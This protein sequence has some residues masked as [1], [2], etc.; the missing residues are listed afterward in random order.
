MSPSSSFSPSKS[1]STRLVREC[2]RAA[3]W[4]H[5][6]EN[7]G[8]CPSFPA[9]SCIFAEQKS[10]GISLTAHLQP[11]AFSVGSYLQLRVRGRA[12]VFLRTYSE[13]YTLELP[14]GCVRW[15]HFFF[16]ISPVSVLNPL[17]LCATAA[18]IPSRGSSFAEQLLSPV[19]A[20]GIGL[21]SSSLP[22]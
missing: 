6:F 11:E 15:E 12:S 21:L 18:W 17:F 7:R 1:R 19:G 22:R 8:M 3:P 5:K 13:E 10:R 2:N 20:R 16:L 4:T 14:S 9:V